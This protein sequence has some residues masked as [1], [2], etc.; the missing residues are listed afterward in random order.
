MINLVSTFS[1]GM[2]PMTKNS[3]GSDV[4]HGNADTKFDG[5]NV[6]MMSLV[7]LQSPKNIFFLRFL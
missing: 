7:Y 3:T 6:D 4:S 1:S 5:W 2:H